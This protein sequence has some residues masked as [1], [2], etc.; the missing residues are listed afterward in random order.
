MSVLNQQYLVILT[1]VINIIYVFQADSIE[2]IYFELNKMKY[3]YFIELRF[4]DIFKVNL[5]VPNCSSGVF[6]ERRSSLQN[7]ISRF[8]PVLKSCIDSINL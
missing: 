1:Y 8:P 6:G 2:A 5:F 7:R 3:F 4:C